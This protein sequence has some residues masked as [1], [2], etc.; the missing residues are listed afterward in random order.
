MGHDPKVPPDFTFD[1]AKIL[2]NLSNA[3]MRAE[4]LSRENYVRRDARD[5]LN[6]LANRCKLAIAEVTDLMGPASRDIIKNEVVN[7]E[8]HLQIDGITTAIIALPEGIRNEI[9]DYVMARYKIYAINLPEE[10]QKS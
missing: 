9:E 8:S 3:K 7:S 5:M 2:T 10:K 4:V 6:R 1:I